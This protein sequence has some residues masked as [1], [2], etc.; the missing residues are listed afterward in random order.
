[1]WHTLLIAT[2]GRQS[3]FLSSNFPT[4][5]GFFNGFGSSRGANSTPRAG[6]REDG[7]R[8]EAE[9]PGIE[10][11]IAAVAQN[12]GISPNVGQQQNLTVAQSGTT[13]ASPST[14]DD[15]VAVALSK[16][17]RPAQ[18][19]KRLP[20]D[21]SNSD[22]DNELENVPPMPQNTGKRKKLPPKEAKKSPR[23]KAIKNSNPKP[24]D[25]AR[26]PA[27]KPRMS[28]GKGQPIVRVTPN[29]SARKKKAPPNNSSKKK[30]AA[31]LKKGDSNSSDSDLERDKRR[32]LSPTRDGRTPQ[33][34][35]IEQKKNAKKARQ[36]PIWKGLRI[37]AKRSKI[38]HATNVSL[39]KYFG[40]QDPNFQN[41]YFFFFFFVCGKI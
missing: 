22:A 33:A 9:M 8:R 23:R 14:S 28:G 17:A 19:D 11:L 2:N 12:E 30:T 5:S 37:K 40:E 13:T 6:G 36:P 20:G 32:S 41:Y 39:Q 4:M 7:G 31:K 16:P 15:E 18:R 10:R 1:M 27:P 25:T 26:S 35:A 34:L 29:T 3:V 21:S 38:F 24:M